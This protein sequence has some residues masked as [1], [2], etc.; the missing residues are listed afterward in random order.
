MISRIKFCCRTRCW[1]HQ[2]GWVRSASGCWSG[3]RTSELNDEEEVRNQ[4]TQNLSCKT[5]TLYSIIF[6]E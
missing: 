2:Y 4:Q 5:I 3:T 1:V 6:S